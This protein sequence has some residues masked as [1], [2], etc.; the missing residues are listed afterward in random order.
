MFR[1]S[2]RSP[3]SHLPCD[4][5]K[6]G[7]RAKDSK[8]CSRIND[9][10]AFTLVELLVV[11][12]IIGI[13]VG[14]LLPAVQAAR[15][16]AR[17]MSCSNNMRQIVLATHNYHGTFNQFP[18]GSIQSN[19]ISPFVAVLSHLEESNNYQ[20]WDFSKSYS[21]PYNREVSSQ[22]IATYLCPSMIL[23]R[24]APDTRIGT[25]GKPVE[26]GAPASY[27]WC[28]GTDDYMKKGDGLFGLNWPGYGYNNPPNR[29]RDCFDGTSSTIA[30]G[31][32]VYDYKDYLWSGSSLPAGMAGTVKWGTARWVVGYPKIALGTTLYPLNVHT[33]ANMGG[34]AS[35]HVGGAY[36]VYADGST[37]FV[38]DSI[39][40]TIYTALATKN[41]S[42]VIAGDAP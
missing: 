29:F 22:K 13:L 19:F 20:Q 16:A 21:D 14:L 1:L 36:F 7:Q 32:T 6:Q 30:L 42:E 31:E 33:A 11:I 28:E 4:F 26:T 10:R 37:R 27:L 41:G 2:I 39:D 24:D 9:R 35:Q 25:T 34:F 12:A 17:K 23:N 5:G 38:T 18:S 8:H 40:Y 15:E 3:F